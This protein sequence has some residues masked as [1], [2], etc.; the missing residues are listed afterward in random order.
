MSNKKKV[1]IISATVLLFAAIIFFSGLYIIQPLLVF[2][3]SGKSSY[4]EN[5]SFENTGSVMIDGK[6][7]G[8]LYLSPEKSGKTLIY[9]GGNMQTSLSSMMAFAGD[10]DQKAIPGYNYLVVD[11]PGY[12]NSKGV[13]GDDSIHEM[14][15]AVLAYVKADDELNNEIDVMG[16]SIGTGA[17]SYA[18][19]DPAVSK[20]ILVAPYDS[21]RSVYNDKINVFYGPIKL[22][23]RYELNS[24]FYAE[25]SN[26]KALIFASRYDEVIPYDSSLELS[27]HF[28]DAD[29]ITIE[30]H[31]AIDGSHNSLLNDET[32]QI[33][34]E[35]LTK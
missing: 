6:Y 7:S 11:I 14:V 33:I 30:P 23:Q 1:L 18:S 35:F 2:P 21:I 26:S 4:G 24:A 31:G 16:F 13:P 28:K 20:V 22:I 25:Q 17:A 12:G 27:E 32:W 8:F 10:E 29:F 34:G 9:F 5:Y 19:K 3:I 15:D